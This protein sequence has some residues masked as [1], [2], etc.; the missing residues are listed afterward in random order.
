MHVQA[1]QIHDIAARAH[2]AGKVVLLGGPSVS[3]SPE[4]YPEIDYLHIGELGDAT[5]QLIARLDESVARPSAQ[6]RLETKDRVPLHDFPIPGYDLIP[7]KNYLM[8]TL[9]FSSG[10]PYLCEFCD[11]PNL[12]GRQPR[13]KT[14]AQVT[15][16]LDAM[17]KQKGHPPVV[18]FV[19]DNFIG[20]RKAAKELLPH[21]LAWQK[22]HD[23]PLQFACEA[24][25]NIAKQTEILALM[26]EARFVTVFAGIE[27]PEADA[28][29]AMRKEHNN[30]VPMMG[31]IKTLNDYGMEVTSG[32]ILGLDS[33]SADTEGRIKDFIEVSQIPILT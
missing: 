3:A 6:L 32:M 19:D 22:K 1:R 17:R 9:Q 4:I 26:R 12:Y 18:Y 13:L 11:I 14:P 33:D 25:L 23:F 31:A 2:K 16:E 20:N 7:L 30:A 5:D 28:L 29:K 24:T 15:A 27:T 21:L 10:C 8:L